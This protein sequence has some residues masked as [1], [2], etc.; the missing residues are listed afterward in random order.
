[1]VATVGARGAR[2]AAPFEIG[3]RVDL[4]LPSKKGSA[5]LDADVVSATVTGCVATCERGIR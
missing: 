3:S 4:P 2:T 5:M 1:V